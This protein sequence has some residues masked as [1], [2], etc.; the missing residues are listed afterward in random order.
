MIVYSSHLVHKYRLTRFK[1]H[2]DIKHLTDTTTKSTKRANNKQIS[3]H[4]KSNISKIYIFTYGA[5]QV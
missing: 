3:Y 5:V 2:G 1:F 4:P